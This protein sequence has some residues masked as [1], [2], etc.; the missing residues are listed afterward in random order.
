MKV[1][2]AVVVAV[3]FAVLLGCSG[4]VKPPTC[5]VSVDGNRVNVV[6]HLPAEDTDYTDTHDLAPAGVSGTP[7][8]VTFEAGGSKVEYSQTGNAYEISYTVVYEKG[9]IAS[10]DVSVKG[11]VYGDTE[12]T[13]TK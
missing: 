13:F 1:A 5:D 8:K 3:L 9:D 10:Y 11:N 2:V 7:T 4:D 6:I 12:Y